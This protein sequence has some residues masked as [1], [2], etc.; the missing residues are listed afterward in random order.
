MYMHM[1]GLSTPLWRHCV[2]LRLLIAQHPYLIP[3]SVSCIARPTEEAALASVAHRIDAFKI[4]GDTPMIY[5]MPTALRL[6]IDRAAVAVSA[7]APMTAAAAE[8]SDLPQSLNPSV[9]NHS[10]GA[11][12]YP[13]AT[14]AAKLLLPVVK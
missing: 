13:V 8:E 3:G 2:K 6:A 1:H 14:P 7:V 10:W 9:A 4:H 12:K 11:L 5:T